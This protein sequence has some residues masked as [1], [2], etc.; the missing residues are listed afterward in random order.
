MLA[1]IRDLNYLELIGETMR[2][3]LNSLAVLLPDWVREQTPQDWF[4]RY[5]Q[6]FSQWQLPKSKPEREDL[7]DLIG[8]DGFELWHMMEKSPE[9]VR[10]PLAMVCA[11]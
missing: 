8:C 10:P 9:W 2:R 5:S 6:P 1:A 3:L 7:A 4:E 11:S